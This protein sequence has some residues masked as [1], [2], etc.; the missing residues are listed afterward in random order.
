MS[1]KIFAW[2]QPARTAF[3]AAAPGSIRPPA[4]MRRAFRAGLIAASQMDEIDDLRRLED[5]AFKRG[6]TLGLKLKT[7]WIVMPAPR[8]PRL[9]RLL[10]ALA[11]TL[12]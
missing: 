1:A 8:F 3:A 6:W 11:R 4:A 5:A 7:D 10:T 2:P 12:I 9:R